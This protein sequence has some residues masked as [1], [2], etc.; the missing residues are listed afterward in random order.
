MQTSLWTEYFP[1]AAATWIKFW[2]THSIGLVHGIETFFIALILQS[3]KSLFIFSLFPD[4]C[5][6][7]VKLVEQ[8]YVKNIKS[9][10]K[11]FFTKLINN[12][13]KNS[14]N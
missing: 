10:K 14:G 9:I 3:F 7:F 6:Q 11:N 4:L 13:I 2:D 8:E 12:K 5:D 1:K